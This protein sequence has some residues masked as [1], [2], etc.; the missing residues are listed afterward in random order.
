M[1]RETAN[2]LVGL[3]GLPIVP[4]VLA[5]LEN[6]VTSPFL[7][8]E[9]RSLNDLGEACTGVRRQQHRDPHQRRGVA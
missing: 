5:D 8:I 6:Q 3:Y 2:R 9:G 1:Q 4:I 7:E